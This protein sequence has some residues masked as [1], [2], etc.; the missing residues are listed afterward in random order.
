MGKLFKILV[1]IEGIPADEAAIHL[2][3]QTAKPDKAKVLLIHVIEMQRTLPVD[4][5]NL[6]AQ[7]RGEQ[8]LIEAERIARAHYSHVES[9]LL[10]ARVAG[11]ALVNEATDRGVDL[12]VMGIPF[13]KLLGEFYL[14]ATANY[15][16]KNAPCPVWLCRERARD[17]N[18]AANA[19][20]K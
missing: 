3:C 15:V 12:I 7:E 13:R 20:Q 10:Q 1:P 4:A 6:P 18:G 8:A 16:F 11:S 2:A 19:N 14:G 9:E 5:E 17:D